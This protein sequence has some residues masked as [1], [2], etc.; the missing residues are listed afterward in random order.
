MKKILVVSEGGGFAFQTKCLLE[1]LENE[2]EIFFLVPQDRQKNREIQSENEFQADGA[3]SDPGLYWKYE[4]FIRFSESKINSVVGVT[5]AIYM[6]R[7]ALF[8]A[9]PANTILDDVYTPMCIIKQNKRVV[10]ANKAFAFDYSSHSVSEEFNRK[11]RTLAGN[12]QLMKLLPWINSPSS[13]PIFWQWFSHKVCR[14]VVPFAL[15]ILVFST[16]L[17]TG[18]FY[19]ILFVAQICFYLLAGLGYIKM[20]KGLNAGLLSLP[21]TFTILNMSAFWALFKFLFSSPEALW[22]KH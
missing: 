15:I 1:K 21:A 12:Y 8:K 18:L 4:K 19:N 17:I 16:Y 7:T 3:S 10:M 9:L 20:K 11:V 14:L 13:N 22:K 2:F 6:M 5:G